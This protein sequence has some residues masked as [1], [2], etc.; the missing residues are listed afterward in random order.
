MGL[1]QE[2]YFELQ[3]E[4]HWDF[5]CYSVDIYHFRKSTKTTIIWLKWLS[6]KLAQNCRKYH[7]SSNARSWTNTAEN[8]LAPQ[9]E[10]HTYI[11]SFSCIWKRVRPKLTIKTPISFQIEN[12]SEYS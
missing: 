10:P 1:N 7:F 6:P 9:I 4:P 3:N 12:I 2:L 11:L 5:Q 8:L